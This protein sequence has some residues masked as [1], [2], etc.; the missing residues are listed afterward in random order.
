MRASPAVGQQQLV[1][2]VRVC[3]REVCVPH[4]PWVSSSWLCVCVCV[5]VCVRVRYA[6]LTSRSR[7]P[8]HDRIAVCNRMT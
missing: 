6:C 2:C 5:C 7:S 8:G 1:V 3:V 4:Q